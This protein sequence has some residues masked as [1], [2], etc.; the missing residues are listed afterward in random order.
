MLL[1]S[2][3]QIMF[4]IGDNVMLGASQTSHDHVAWG[5]EP[6]TNIPPSS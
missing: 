6:L 1:Y 4:T 5:F 3:V 2:D